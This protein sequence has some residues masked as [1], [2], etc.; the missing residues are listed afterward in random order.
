MSLLQDLKQLRYLPR[1]ALGSNV[2]IPRLYG[3][4]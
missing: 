2:W 4:L 3:G 1:E